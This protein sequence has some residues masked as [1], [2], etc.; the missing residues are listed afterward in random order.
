MAHLDANQ[1]KS[2]D[3]PTGGRGRVR[4]RWTFAPLDTV[5]VGLALWTAYY[6]AALLIGGPVA[7]VTAASVA[8]FGVLLVT[9]G[10]QARSLRAGSTAVLRSDAP[11]PNATVAATAFGAAVLSLIANRPDADDVFYVNRSAA[12]EALGVL[13]LRDTMY[14]DQTF[15]MIPGQFPPVASFEALLGTIAHVIG[16]PAASVTYLAV[17]PIASALAVLALWRLLSSW[18][19]PR[20]IVA[21]VVAVTYLLFGGAFHASFGNTWVER[22]WQGKILFVSILIPTLLVYLVRCIRIGSRRETAL[23]AAAAVA[24]VGLTSTA[25]FVLPIFFAVAGIAALLLGHRERLVPLLLPM[26]YLFVVGLAWLALW[27]SNVALPEE[28]GEPGTAASVALVPASAAIVTKVMGTGAYLAIG[29]AAGML[30]WAAIRQRHARVLVLLLVVTTS[31]SVS[32]LGLAAMEVIGLP[33]SIRWR[34]MWLVPV[35]SLLGALVAGASARLG[36]QGAFAAGAAAAVL[37]ALAGLPLWSPAN[38][39]SLGRPVWKWSAEIRQEHEQIAQVSTAGD[40]VGVPEAVGAMVTAVSGNVWSVNPRGSYT[41]GMAFQ[42]GFC[43]D[44]R[45]LVAAYAEGLV[46][47]QI[48]VRRA[49]DALGVSVLAVSNDADVASLRSLGFQPVGRHGLL[50]RE[51]A[52]GLGCR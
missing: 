24:G 22:M 50:R 3:A 7:S 14:A 18:E 9:I 40:V 20:P 41:Q 11:A 39:V 33:A 4:G 46:P 51:A 16:V 1:R 35:P 38:G 25:I 15:S 34:M 27:R 2:V 49:L 45:F 19:V 36:R 29:L 5:V 44:E 47:L 10:W 31:L 23:A 8:L 12:V 42:E 32:P 43:A 28:V 52:E 6:Q 21:F 13:P 17:P 30:G 48:D 26:A 37:V